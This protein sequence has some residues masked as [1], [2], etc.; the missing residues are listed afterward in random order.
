[1][2]YC[3]QNDLETLITVTELVELTTER[4]D[5]PNPTIITE[6]IDRVDT[7]IDS[8]VS[9]RYA[10]PLVSV[11]DIIKGLSVDMVIF[12]LYSRRSA[13]PSIRRTKYEDA[14]KFLQNVASGNSNIIGSDGYE[15]SKKLSSS[16]E[17]NSSERIFSKKN[18]GN[19]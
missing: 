7:E 17:I 1:M 3:N 2:P 19:Y 5:I 6:I 14:V 4:G 18:W 12:H 13:V 9:V 8:Y 15:T 11:P 16:A 10:T